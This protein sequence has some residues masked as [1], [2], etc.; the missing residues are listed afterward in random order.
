MLGNSI[1]SVRLGGIYAL[2]RLAEEYPEQ[3][4]IQIMQLFCA[5]VR[6]P[7]G[8]AKGP[9]WDYD[10]NG[11]PI[12]GLREDVQAVMY[13]IGRR[14]NAG[15]YLGL[16]AGNFRLDLQNVNLQHGDLSYL[17]LSNASLDNTDLS[18]TSLQRSNLY[19]ASLMGSNLSDASLVDANLYSASLFGANLSGTSLM[20][21]NLFN[22]SFLHAD[23]SY[24]RLA[25]A[26]LTGADLSGAN[27]T[28][29]SF[30]ILVWNG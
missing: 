11:E 1:L 9:V 19:G 18:N 17:N 15:I 23:L 16:S 7:T 28:G 3:Y 25:G 10:H 29:A 4:R 12:F 20:G 21:A 26:N 13:A 8:E 24:A 2:Q 14:G 22:A 27:L 6:N 30:N 5:F